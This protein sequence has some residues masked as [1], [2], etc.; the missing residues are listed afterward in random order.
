MLVPLLEH[1]L[2]SQSGLHRPLGVIVELQGSDYV[3]FARGLDLERGVHT[4]VFLFKHHPKSQRAEILVAGSASLP[5]LH[6]EEPMQAEFYD[7]FNYLLD[8][9][10][11]QDL[12]LE[13]GELLVRLPNVEA[14]ERYRRRAETTLNLSM[15]DRPK[16]IAEYQWRITTP[17]AVVLLALLA[18]PLS[19]TTPLESRFRNFAIA[20]LVYIALFS[21][22]S[23]LRTAIEQERMGALPGLWTAY[24]VEALLLAI[25]VSR[26]RVKRR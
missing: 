21:M 18:V 4:D 14:R 9:R 11:K 26:P 7:G 24:A 5:V 17:L 22:I 25:L 15:S 13:F 1:L 16:D 10:G 6:P 20:L 8:H 12:T 19:R 3:F 2:H 23:M